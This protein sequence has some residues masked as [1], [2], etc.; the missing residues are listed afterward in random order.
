MDVDYAFQVDFATQKKLKYSGTSLSSS[1]PVILTHGDVFTED[2]DVIAILFK[3]V[4]RNKI[5]NP[6]SGIWIGL[7]DGK[8]VN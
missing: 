1:C 3:N 7:K 2:I 4:N 6:V 5:V 8:K